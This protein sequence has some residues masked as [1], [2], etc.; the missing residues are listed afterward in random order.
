MKN[1]KDVNEIAKLN[2][3]GQITI[4]NALRKFYL[5]G[6]QFVGFKITPAGILL[7]PLEVKER[8]PYTSEEWKKI[9]EL[10]SHKGKIYKTVKDAKKHIDAL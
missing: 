5:N 8:D 9:E 3:K 2:V 6:S 10:A 4:P 1:T 7:V